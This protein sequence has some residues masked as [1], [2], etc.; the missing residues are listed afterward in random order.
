MVFHAG[1]IVDAYKPMIFQM[2]DHLIENGQL[3]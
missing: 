3:K 2:N 1:L